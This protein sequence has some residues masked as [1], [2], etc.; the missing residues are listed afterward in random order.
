MSTMPHLTT[1]PTG[2]DDILDRLFDAIRDQNSRGVREIL[3]QRPGLVNKFN[4][5]RPETPQWLFDNKRFEYIL[6]QD[7]LRRDLEDENVVTGLCLQKPLHLACIIGDMETVK[8]LLEQKN[9]DLE[10]ENTSGETS[11]SLAC[12][13]AN[14]HTAKFL[15]EKGFKLSPNMDDNAGK[16]PLDYLIYRESY[17]EWSDNLLEDQSEVLGKL[18]EK[19][20]DEFQDDKF[21][22]RLLRSVIENGNLPMFKAVLKGWWGKPDV[23]TPDGRGYTLLSLAERRSHAKMVEMLSDRGA[24]PVAQ[25]EQLERKKAGELAMRSSNGLEAAQRVRESSSNGVDHT[26]IKHQCWRWV[27]HDSHRKEKEQRKVHASAV[28]DLINSY[29]REDKPLTQGET[30]WCHFEANSVGI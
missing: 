30:L 21:N 1:A 19:I 7:I 18:T 12:R 11:F 4:E 23:N 15:L 9:I 10:N 28:Q 22:D 24:N 27:S 8:V 6:T 26:G 2:A 20:M 13:S 16:R 3:N 14:L 25:T 5:F 17:P 29:R